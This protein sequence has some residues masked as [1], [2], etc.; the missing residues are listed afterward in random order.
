MDEGVGWN[1]NKLL[2]KDLLLEFTFWYL[3]VSASLK[4]TMHR[5]EIFKEAAQLLYSIKRGLY[6]DVDSFIWKEIR[7]C[8][9]RIDSSMVFPYLIT[10]M[11]SDAGLVG[12]EGDTGIT[13][14]THSFNLMSRNNL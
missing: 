14:H 10:E 2:R 5:S 3:F 8:G 12:I 6:I 1:G 9:K 13:I 11:C 7:G 4:P